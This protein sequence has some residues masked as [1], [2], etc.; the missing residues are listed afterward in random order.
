MNESKSPLPPRSPADVDFPY[1]QVEADH[2]SRREF[3]KFLCLVSGGMALG[4]G[5]VAVKDKIAPP[6]RIEGMEF[7]AEVG[8]IPRG[9]THPFTLKGKKAPYMLLHLND[10]T[11]RCYEQRC[12]HL[13]CATYYSPEHDHIECPCHH[14]A[15]DVRTGAVL[16]GPPP[17]PLPQLEVVR[18]G[19]KLFIRE[20]RKTKSEPQLIRKQNRASDSPN[21]TA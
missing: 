7:V 4:S 11:F 19:D 12:T 5:F 18:V 16:K 17:R 20:F 15:F 21:R 3:A 1:E 10:G 13:A 14:G 8:D 6:F 9:G 2:V